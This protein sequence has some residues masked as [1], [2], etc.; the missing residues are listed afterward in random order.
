MGGMTG[1]RPRSIPQSERFREVTDMEV[2]DVED[3][4]LVG[5]VGSVR[6]HMGGESFLGQLGVL[7]NL[8]SVTRSTGK[9]MLSEPFPSKPIFRTLAAP[10]S[11]VPHIQYP[12]R[13]T[14]S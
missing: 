3:L 2:A 4:F 14:L 5:R 7:P 6:S 1:D 10:R 13:Q 8:F 9:R 11:P 12:F